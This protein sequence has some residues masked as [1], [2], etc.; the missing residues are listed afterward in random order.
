[1]ASQDCID[2]IRKAFGGDR[3]LSDDEIEALVDA[4]F[5][6]AG[7][8]ATAEDFVRA[9]EQVAQD[10]Q[11]AAHVERRNRRLNISAK[12]RLLSMAREANDK[13]GKPELGLRAA[14]VG[15][16]RRLEGGRLSADAVTQSLQAEYLGGLLADLE[17][18]ELLIDFNS[19]HMDLD[20]ARALEKITR[21]GA[22]GSASKAAQQIAEIVHKHRRIAFDRRNRAGAW[23]KRLS[24][25][26]VRQAHDMDRLRRA[27]FEAWRD[28]ILPLLDHERT[29]GDAEDVD[30]FLREA[31]NTLASGEQFRTGQA[32]IDLRL[33]FTGPGNL[34]KRRAQSRVLH[35]KDADAW[36]AYN[37]Q[38]GRRTFREAL[39]AEFAGF[40][41][42]TALFETFGT[43]PRALFDEVR[44]DIRQQ[45][46]TESNKLD[47]LRNELI[48]AEFDVV[49]GLSSI[50]AN[51]T[52]AAVATWVRAVQSMSKLGAATLSSIAD[53]GA[54]GAAIRYSD[55]TGPLTAMRD[56]V[57]SSLDG[58]SGKDKRIIA[59]DIGV[60]GDA[61]VGDL[62]AS[63]FNAEDSVAG[64][65]Q[66][67]MR[68]FFKLNLL[69]QWTDGHKRG[70]GMVISRNLARASKQSFDQIEPQ[71]RAN[72]E[73][74]GIDARQWD[75]AR[76]AVS[77]A[78]DGREYL[79]PSEI[80]RFDI[81]QRD[82][83]Q[84]ET[85]IRA[86][87]VDITE[88]GVPTPGARERALLTLGA[89]PGTNLG[90]A[91]RFVAQFKAFP[92]TVATKV[93][94]RQLYANADGSADKLGL[95]MYIA[96]S[97]AL[98]YAALAAKDIVKG[99]TPRDPLDPKTWVAALVQGGG[100]GIYGDF[101]FGEFN[102]F[103]RSF[104]S[105]LAGPT[106]GTV[107]SLAELWARF[108]NGD[109]TAGAA[110]R[111]AMQNT[112]FINLFYTRMAMDYLVLYHLQE[113]ANPGYLRRSE[114]RLKREQGQTHLFPPSSVVP[115]GGD[116]LALG[117]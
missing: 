84:I 78:D 112:P 28:E 21:P 75:I 86:F 99:R 37:K 29:F 72:L 22:K 110:L 59:E 40:A 83:D 57:V 105:T 44:S 76:Q 31:F 18:A 52:K 82:K 12:Q 115:R 45:F 73:T 16:N 67:T 54:K 7:R 90:E 103:G 65:A 53:I 4:V 85:R 89:R 26:I 42:D 80:K 111:I 94:G 91:M 117:R 104:L 47:G 11:T 14:T 34:A 62:A 114:R 107:D 36:D 24:G 9:A 3:D 106:L 1:M 109:D 2:A 51:P 48:Q 113:M 81:S 70:L 55:G 38:F 46:R 101:L 63:R 32:D 43:N 79:F 92:V 6:R 50:P 97:T 30:E 8:A 116:L 58:F 98:G 60:Y 13:F 77:K 17:R 33:A 49:E 56:S 5:S 95:A 64:T 25:F 100:A 93:I 69:T 19:G 35:F 15:I 68:A 88:A 102:R 39:V 23:T 87:I 20:V 66:K 41:R 71:L 96:S 74:F 27:G 10:I 61:V 108:R